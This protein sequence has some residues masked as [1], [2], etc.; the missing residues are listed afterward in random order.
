MIEY[1][2]IIKE[3]V[4][5]RDY[6]EAIGITLDRNGMVCCPIHGE[7]T[8]SL[9]VYDDPRRGWHCFGCHAGGDVIDM[10]CKVEGVGFIEAIKRIDARFNLGI[11]F[12]RPTDKEAV[13]KAQ[14]EMARINK[15]RETRRKKEQAAE[16]AYWTAY[17]KW[18]HNENVILDQAPKTIED[19]IT[20]EF[21]YAITHR[22]EHLE[23]VEDALETWRR[24]RR[25]RYGYTSSKVETA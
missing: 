11:P 17:D 6:L 4:S 7:K 14:K 16:R 15:A 13:L 8:P 25:E 18:L 10:V 5:T 12:S 3:R 19:E 22:T 23:A 24:L 9:K 21:A 2:P 20:D 1:T